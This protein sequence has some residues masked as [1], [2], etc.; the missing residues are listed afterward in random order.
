MITNSYIIKDISMTWIRFTQWL[1][2][3]YNKLVMCENGI[4]I[5]IIIII[6]IMTYET[7]DFN[8]LLFKG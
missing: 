8:R 3:M 5:I 2:K 6:T 4:I 1:S 7:S